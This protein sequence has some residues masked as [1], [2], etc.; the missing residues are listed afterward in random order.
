MTYY[1][2]IILIFYD[3]KQKVITFNQK[4]CALIKNTL[5]LMRTEGFI[6][7]FEF[8]T[9]SCCEINNFVCSNLK[10]FPSKK[11]KK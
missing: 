7:L 4:D 10:Y 8:I 9:N 1:S 6:S 5:N 2:S 3:C 11:K